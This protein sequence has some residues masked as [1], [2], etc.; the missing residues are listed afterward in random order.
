V[1]SYC[2]CG[3]QKKIFLEISSFLFLLASLLARFSF[4]LLYS[5]HYFLLLPRL[6][7]HFGIDD[8]RHC[9]HQEPYWA[10]A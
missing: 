9:F 5:F 10:L 2:G 6:L 1:E 8:P 7:R 4:P 3:G